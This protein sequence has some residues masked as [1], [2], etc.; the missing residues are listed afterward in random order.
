MKRTLLILVLA[1]VILAGTAPMIAPA[2][3]MSEMAE[4]YCGMWAGC[5]HCPGAGI[6]CLWAIATDDWFDDIM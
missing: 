3:A 2:Q 1:V 5:P 4:Y 6:L